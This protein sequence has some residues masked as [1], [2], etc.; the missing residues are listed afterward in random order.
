MAV[1]PFGLAEVRYHELVAERRRRALDAR[2]FRAA[3][4]ALAV[5]DG[6]GRMWVLGPE[7]GTWYR[8]DPDRWVPAEP[9]RRLVCPHCGHH[10]LTRHSFCVDCGRRLSRS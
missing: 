9:P 8:R 10:N 2:A 7:D 3:V 4:R 1:D 5:S 6:E